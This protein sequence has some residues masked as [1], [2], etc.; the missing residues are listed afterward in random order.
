MPSTCREFGHRWAADVP[1]CC[2]RCVYCS[3]VVDGPTID[4]RDPQVRYDEPVE[5]PDDYAGEQE[6]VV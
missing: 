3:A 2:W 6:A 1:R 5:D 4:L